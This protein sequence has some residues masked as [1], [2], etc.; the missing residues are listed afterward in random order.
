MMKTEKPTTM[1]STMDCGCCRPTK[2]TK[3][4]VFGLLPRPIVPRQPCCSPR[5]IDV[6]FWKPERVLHCQ[7]LAPQ[8]SQCSQPPACFQ[9]EPVTRKNIVYASENQ[10]RQDPSRRSL[11]DRQ[12]VNYVDD[13]FPF[14]TSEGRSEPAAGETSEG[15]NS[16]SLPSSSFVAGW[17]S[18]LG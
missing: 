14:S 18:R 1:P 16:F 13:C 17:G 10:L 5:S 9:N 6:F 4:F 7:L 12:F 8:S 15:E 11:H 3:A 2:P